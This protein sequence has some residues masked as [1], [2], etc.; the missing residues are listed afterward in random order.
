MKAKSG[1]VSRSCDI[2]NL[3]WLEICVKFQGWLPFSAAVFSL[4]YIS[5]LELVTFFL[6]ALFSDFG[7]KRHR[8]SPYLF[9]NGHKSV[10]S[11]RFNWAAGQFRVHGPAKRSI[12]NKILRFYGK[13]S[14]CFTI[15]SFTNKKTIYGQDDEAR[16]AEESWP[17]TDESFSKNEKRMR[18]EL[19]RQT[20]HSY[21]LDKPTKEAWPNS[22]TASD[23]STCP[24][25]ED[26]L[27]RRY[28]FG[29]LF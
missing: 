10:R 15:N 8:R 14:I 9:F 5:W 12:F 7:Q 19:L 25:N 22:H 11:R 1:W 6:A 28:C 20:Q 24:K 4:S 21:F 17:A 23:E 18:R 16:S 29:H 26:R 3:Y 13:S 27:T 2:W